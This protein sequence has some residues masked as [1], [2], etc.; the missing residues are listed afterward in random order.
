MNARR[1]VLI[2]AGGVENIIKE[3]YAH[4]ENDIEVMHGKPAAWKPGNVLWQVSTG[5]YTPSQKMDRKR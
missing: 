5:R 1:G 3:Q 4:T 2:S